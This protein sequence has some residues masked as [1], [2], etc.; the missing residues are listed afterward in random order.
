M[1]LLFR[2]GLSLGI[3]YF[4]FRGVDFSAVAGQ[5]ERIR[6][7]PILS[8]L[9]LLTLSTCLAAMR[10][11]LIATEIGSPLPNLP[12]FLRSFY[13]GAFL[14][15]GL[16]TT[17]GGDALRVI[18]VA[19]VVNNRRLA[20]SCVLFDRVVGLSGLLLLNV[21]MFPWA[22]ELLPRP[23]AYAVAGISAA[24]LFTI[25]GLLFLPW[26]LVSHHHA[27]LDLIADINAFGHRVLTHPRRLFYQCLLSLG[28]HFSAILA[29][30]VLARQFGVTADLTA[31]LVIQPSVFIAVTLP[32]SLAGWGV[33]EGSMAAM[34]AAIGVSVPAIMATSL[35]FG[36]VALVATLPGLAFMMAGQRSRPAASEQ[37]IP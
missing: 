23:L 7:I 29:M 2:V 17:L 20:F 26:H 6:P 21:L 16:P 3:L 24:A 33:R 18:D 35:T 5:F 9:L 14:N 10:W 25:A 37:S 4:A 1:K 30:H 27:L 19:R 13:R 22:I 11:R 31:Q 8:A 28:V 32:I 12:F 15:Q 34:F 36:V